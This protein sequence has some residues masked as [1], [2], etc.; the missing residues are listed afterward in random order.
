MPTFAGTTVS[1]TELV[2][3]IVIGVIILCCFG[4]VVV[5]LLRSLCSSVRLF[6]SVLCCCERAVFCGARASKLVDPSTP[7][8]NHA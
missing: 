2:G 4:C 3:G 8:H 5:L 6:F 1:D 7:I